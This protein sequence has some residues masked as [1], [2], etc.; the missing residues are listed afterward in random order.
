MGALLI[1]QLRVKVARVSVLLAVL[2]LGAST[3][4]CGGDADDCSAGTAAAGT[5]SGGA[6]GSATGGSGATSGAAGASGSSTGTGGSGGMMAAT[7]GAGGLGAPMPVEC[8]TTTCEPDPMGSAFIRPCCVDMAT[9]T[10]GTM[11]P[12]IGMCAEPVDPDP[13]CDS[14]MVMSFVIPSCC[15]ADNRC[16]ISSA[17]FSADACTSIEDITAMF[18]MPD[19]GA[20]DGGTGDG[21]MPDGGGGMMGMNPFGATLPAPKA[22]E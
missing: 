15:T 6:A 18:E 12:L 20:D 10:C 22:C 8:G 9:A 11:L 16:G 5:G 21:G 1:N 3:F 14:I 2:A 13:R 17:M 7:G 19:G 4:G